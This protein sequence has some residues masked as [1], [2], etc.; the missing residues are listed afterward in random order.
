LKKRKN[1]MIEAIES[2]TLRPGYSLDERQEI[3]KM[4]QEELAK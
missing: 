1:R 3:L 4:M 2:E